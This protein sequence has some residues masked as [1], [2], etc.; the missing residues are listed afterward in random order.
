MTPITIESPSDPRLADYR[1]LRQRSG[2]RAEDD[3]YFT[4]EG[5]LIVRRLLSSDFDVRSI[6]VEK[7]RD[8]ELPELTNRPEAPVYE[9]TRD[10]IE[11]V[12]GF[13]FHRGYLASAERKRTPGIEDFVTDP[14]S[15]ALLNVYDMENM[16]SLIRSAAAFGIRQVLVDSRSVDP[17]ARRVLR[18]SMGAVFGMRFVKF[19]DPQRCLD[20]IGESG[21]ITLA[22]TLNEGAEPIGRFS[23]SDAP[24]VLILGNEADGIPERVQQAADHR[25]TIEMKANA[26]SR[27]LVDSLNVSVAGA[28]CMHELTR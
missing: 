12:A 20:R 28:I 21:A 5:K 8:L 1:N 15:V 6:V 7:G 4:C 26:T 27:D 14:V 18:V 25:V 2:A 13:H 23:G 19:D 16:G 10:Q 11:S 17:F 22:T 24:M 3:T 9:L